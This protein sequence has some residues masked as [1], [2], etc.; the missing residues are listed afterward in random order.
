ML[1]MIAECFILSRAVL[2][3]LVL[4]TIRCLLLILKILF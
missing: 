1:E 4:L 2:Y 3:S